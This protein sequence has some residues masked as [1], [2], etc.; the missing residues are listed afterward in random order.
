MSMNSQLPGPA[1]APLPAIDL[2]GRVVVLTGGAAGLGRAAALTLAR[3]GA[4][5]GILDKSAKGIE[6]VVGEIEAAGGKAWG[7]A[8]DITDEQAV[9]RAISQ[10]VER[11]SNI[12]VLI[13]CAGIFDGLR[14]AASTSNEL[15][16]RVIAVNLTAA[17]VMTRAVLPYMTRAGRGSIINVASEAGLRG[18]CGGAAYVAS[19]HGLVGLTRSVAWS[20][21]TSGIRCN[22]VCPGAIGETDIMNDSA[23]DPADAE[24]FLPVMS[25][26]TEGRPQSI[27]DAVLFLASDLSAFVNGVMLPVDGGWSAG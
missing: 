1:A 17:F 24:I 22:A 13:N 16:N 14:P 8:A 27:A 15:W 26:A 7:A 12:D 6:A 25:L 11:W 4:F 2:T 23:I 19:K 3:H 10:L 20:Y 21:R 5:I 18:G 9:D